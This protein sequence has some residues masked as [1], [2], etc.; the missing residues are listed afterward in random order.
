MEHGEIINL[1]NLHYHLVNLIQFMCHARQHMNVYIC[2][3]STYTVHTFMHCCT[4]TT[5]TSVRTLV[6]QS[7]S[8]LLE[9]ILRTTYAWCQCQLAACRETCQH[10]KEVPISHVYCRDSTLVSLKTFVFQPHFATDGFLS[11]FLWWWLKH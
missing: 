7:P 6:S 10:S 8:I 3:C 11:F 1:F 9:V 4:C 5:R 2:T